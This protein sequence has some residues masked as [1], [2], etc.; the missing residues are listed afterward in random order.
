MNFGAPYMTGLLWILPI[1]AFFMFWAKA[2]K[3][4]IGNRFIEPALWKELSKNVSNRKRVFKIFM[5]L[6]GLFF[7]IFGFL[8]P[9]WGFT[10][11]EIRQ[12]GVDIL[13][14]LDTSKSMLA[15]DIKPN[16]LERSRLGIKD[17][18][19]KLSGDRVGLIAFSGTAFLQCPLTIDYNGFLLALGDVN[20]NTIPIGGTAIGSAVDTAIKSYTAGKQK[21]KILIIIT[22]GEDLEG[23]L[24]RAARQAKANG[25]TIYT[26][27]IGTN[28][29][30]II[31]VRDD[32]GKIIFQKGPDGEVIKTRLD[33]TALQRLALD[34]GGMYVR[35]G[36]AEFGLD[37]IYEQRI[38]KIEKEQFKTRKEKLYHERFQIFLIIAFILL[39]IEALIGERG[40]N[41]I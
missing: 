38:S 2:Q 17:L 8:R 19:K 18:I 31:P 13:I 33:E 32:S 27:G 40:K 41:G 5:T 12:E 7:I 24:E 28:E 9:E 10:W 26:V 30:E 23:G 1:M 6:G 21:N 39:S 34:T 3:K 25:I 22:D 37:I 20:I 35:S 4:H 11:Q 29:G 15:E 16:R 14:A 36:G